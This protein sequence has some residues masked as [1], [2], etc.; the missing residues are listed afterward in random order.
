MQLK[1]RKS[2]LPTVFAVL[3]FLV[4]G[5]IFFSSFTNSSSFQS[6]YVAPF[7]P[8]GKGSSDIVIAGDS[9]TVPLTVKQ[10]EGCTLYDENGKDCL[11]VHL[12]S[13]VQDPAPIAESD[14]TVVD[15]FIESISGKFEQFGIEIISVKYNLAG[16]KQSFSTVFP[17]QLIKGNI[18]SDDFIVDNV[19]IAFNA[20][21][22]DRYSQ[23]NLEGV[24]EFQLN[25]KV[26][27]TKKLWTSS[28]LAGEQTV[29]LNIVDEVP[30]PIDKR[31]TVF[32]FTFTDEG[33]QTGDKP[34]FVVILKSL[35]GDYTANGEKKLFDWE[36]SFTAYQL[37]LVVNENKK[38]ILEES[39]SVVSVNKDDDTLIVCAQS[40]WQTNKSINFNRNHSYFV[41]DIPASTTLPVVVTDAGGSKIGEMPAFTG[42]VAPN[43]TTR[44]TCSGK[45]SDTCLQVAG[46][47]KPN[48][49]CR[50]ITG[51]ERNKSY[52]IMVDGTDFLVTTPTEQHNYQVTFSTS[53]KIGL[54]PKCNPSNCG[55]TLTGYT[56]NDLPLK[57]PVT[58]NFGFVKP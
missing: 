13:V 6:S 57:Y 38:S 15:N 55:N 46:S 22:K 20:I 42:A 28:S 24:V 27:A 52:I 29:R 56:Q 36:G 2:K 16:E 14:K 44:T 23:F 48:L 39:G 18:L 1:K 45:T 43:P 51:L 3:V 8:S 49:D 12:I 58:S 35:K 5:F 37:D 7:I 25:G 47:P 34:I 21:T 31:P 26:V 33:F 32:D 4:V 30:P 19:Q 41:R 40:S 50:K 53:G 10:E 54:V 17:V 11:V 9:G